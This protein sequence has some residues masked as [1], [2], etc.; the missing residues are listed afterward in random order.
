MANT[1]IAYRE[2]RFHIEDAHTDAFVFIENISKD[3]MLG[4]EGWHHKQFPAT[5]SVK[6]IMGAWHSGQENPLFWPLNAPVQQAV[7]REVK[8]VEILHMRNV[9]HDATAGGVP[10]IMHPITLVKLLNDLEESRRLLY[11][12]R[13]THAHLL[14]GIR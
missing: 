1:E 8:E 9:A 10:V 4:V 6:D 5:M 7:C 11:H 13:E 12:I 2:A 3:G 14:V